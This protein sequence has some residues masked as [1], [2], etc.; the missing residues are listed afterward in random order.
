[1]RVI[2]GLTLV[3]DGK[4]EMRGTSSGYKSSSVSRGMCSVTAKVCIPHE[5]AVWI[6]S[7]RASFAWPGQNCPEW[8][9]IEKAMMGRFEVS[10]E[11]KMGGTRLDKALSTQD[12]R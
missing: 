3:A 12:S 5:T 7:S 9:C 11:G 2:P 8:L 10:K 1:M 4:G 6:M